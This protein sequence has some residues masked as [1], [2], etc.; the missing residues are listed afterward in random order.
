MPYARPGRSRPQPFPARRRTPW[1]AARTVGVFGQTL[2][3]QLAPWN[4]TVVVYIAWDA[5]TAAN[6]Q[7]IDVTPFVNA[8]AGISIS[9]GRTDGLS[10]V[11]VGTISMTVDN[12]DGR[13]TATNTAGAWYGSIRKGAWI[14]V[15]VVPPSGNAS[16]RFVGFITQLPVTWTGFQADTQLTASDRFLFMG[17]SR[18][19]LPM[20]SSEVL[21]DTSTGPLVAAH[22]PLTEASGSTSGGDI[23]GNASPPLVPTSWG[24]QGTGTAGLKFGGQA[25]PGFDGTSSV[26]F[27]PTT[28]SAGSVLQTTVANWNTYAGAHSY[29]VLELWLNTSVQG[30]VGQFACLY[31]PAGANALTF[32]VDSTGYLA[33]SSEATTAAS[34][35]SNLNVVILTP[36]NAVT[37][38]YLADGQWHYISIAINNN[39]SGLAVFVVNIDGK[40]SLTTGYFITTS[41]NLTTLIIGGGWTFTPAQQCFTGSIAGVSWI[42]TGT[43]ASNY[44]AHYLAGAT[45]FY[46]ESVDSRIARIARYAGIPQPTALQSPAAGFNPVPVYVPGSLGAWTNLGAC[47]HQVGTQS[48]VGRQPLDVCQ[49]AA[50]TENM[51]V[52]INRPGYLTIQP[53]TTRYNASAAWTVNALD[54]DPSS[55]IS[56]D[57]QYYAN[58]MTVTPNGQAAIIVDG[59]AGTASQALNSVYSQS[60]ATASL[61]PADAVNLA[62]AAVAAGSN[63]PPRLNLAVEVASLSKQAGYGAAWYDAVLA[64]DIS[65]VVTVTNMPAQAP[66]PSMSVF[67]EGYTETIGENTHTFAW[68]VS[69]QTNT[70]VYQCDSP[71]LG[72]VDTAGIT[73]AY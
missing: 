31:D 63:P 24:P 56:D 32:S 22:Y 49:E 18:K 9:H 47:V 16:T 29:G 48:I 8:A 42:L 66:A 55:T 2:A 65:S 70:S 61:N 26:T 45:G 17:Q 34:A 20:I 37:P 40:T 13:W 28:Q 51:P 21:F 60:L 33:I 10:D 23:S 69:Q 14:R 6:P 19:L 43:A 73:L 30:T 44:P 38:V 58:E 71:S 50:R 68:A 12:N 62:L 35:Y 46:G 52:Y 54:I 72:L 5:A 41:P 57:Y 25:G 7:W 1:R 27:S 4:F 59:P 36:G 15:D 53:C 11:S 64:S 39:A 3:Q 67:L